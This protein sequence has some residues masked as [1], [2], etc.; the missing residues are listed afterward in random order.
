DSRRVAWLKRMEWIRGSAFALAARRRS[1][2]VSASP[3]RRAYGCSS[4]APTSH[5]QKAVT[6]EFQHIARACS[7]LCLVEQ[8]HF[9]LEPRS[10]DIA[11]LDHHDLRI[12]FQQRRAF[13]GLFDPER[14]HL[15]R[16]T[17]ATVN[18]EQPPTGKVILSLLAVLEH[19]DGLIIRQ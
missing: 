17:R 4:S 5:R 9:D 19:N 16:R 11:V 7:L 13:S 15:A 2:C 18:K 1:G 12:V 6:G 14:C 10:A 8:Q 3:R